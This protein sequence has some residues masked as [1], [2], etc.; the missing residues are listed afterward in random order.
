LKPHPP[1]GQLTLTVTV[2]TFPPYTAEVQSITCSGP[3]LTPGALSYA[4]NLLVAIG[5]WVESQATVG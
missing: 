3:G 2:P 5:M 1:A 4:S